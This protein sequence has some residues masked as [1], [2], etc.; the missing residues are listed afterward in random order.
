M[1]SCKHIWIIAGIIGG[2]IFMFLPI[3]GPIALINYYG[4]KRD[5]WKKY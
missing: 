3:T 2:L 5:K 1:Y 4:K